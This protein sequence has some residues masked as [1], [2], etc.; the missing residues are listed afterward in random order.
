MTGEEKFKVWW[1]EEEGIRR[2]KSRGDFEEEDA[3]RQ[4]AEILRIAESRPGK[5]LV[6]NDLTEAGKASS[7]ARKRYAQLLQSDRIARH[8][9]VG[10]RTLTRVIVSFLVRASGAENAMFFA[11]EEEALKWLREDVEDG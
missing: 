10:M 3:K 4:M 2:T 6:L 8:A 7:G 5:V 9:F 11:T 1:D